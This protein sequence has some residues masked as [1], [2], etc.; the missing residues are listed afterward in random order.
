MEKFDALD[1]FDSLIDLVYDQ[2]DW[3]PLALMAKLSEE[4]GELAEAALVNEGA[5]K[6]ELK[7][8]IDGEVSDVINCAVAVGVKVLMKRGV[9]RREIKSQIYD[10]LFIKLEKYKD[11]LSKLRVEQKKIDAFNSIIVGRMEVY[12]DPRTF[13]DV[14]TASLTFKGEDYKVR[15]MIEPFSLKCILVE[16]V[17][18]DN[19]PVD[20]PEIVEY[21]T[22][23]YK[24]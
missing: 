13:R 4:T 20:I 15:Y 23:Q 3:E 5:I 21:F 16:L 14:V 10:S 18:K 8:D 22:V 19:Q 17:D 2:E 7:E 12:N 6:K 11:N 9:A 1:Y 24:R